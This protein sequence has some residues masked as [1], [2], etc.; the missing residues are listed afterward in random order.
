MD[1]RLRGE[2]DTGGARARDWLRFVLRAGT[3]FL[4]RRG[5]K[6]FRFKPQRQPTK[7]A[8]LLPRNFDH[9][10]RLLK[11]LQKVAAAKQCTVAQLSLAWILHQG[12]F[13]VPIPGT[14]QISHLE[15]NVR[16]AN[17]VLSPEELSALDGLFPR[18]GAAAGAR[19]D[20]DR[21]KELNI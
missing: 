4:C 3:G 12:D 2:H 21:S 17:V 16:G 10:A 14:L 20:K 13:F 6:S 9:N 15:E 11:E 19:H 18:N 7:S 5:E 1:P 8:A